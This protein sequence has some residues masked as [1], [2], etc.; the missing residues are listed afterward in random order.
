MVPMVYWA[1]PVFALTLAQIYNDACSRAHRKYP[2]RFIGRAMLPMQ[3][4]ELA[5]RSSNAREAART[6]GVMMAT[7][8]KRQDLDDKA[9]FPIYA[10]CEEASDGRLHPSDGSA[11]R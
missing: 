7:A 5:L 8:I 10:K 1:P 3:Q 9:F 4:P 6:R 2:Q 11:R